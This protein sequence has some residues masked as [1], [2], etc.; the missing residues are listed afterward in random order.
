MPRLASS[1]ANACPVRRGNVSQQITSMPVPSCTSLLACVKKSAT[2][3]EREYVRIISPLLTKRW[4]SSQIFWLASSMSSMISSCITSLM[5]YGRGEGQ[6]PPPATPACPECGQI[7]CAREPTRR[8]WTARIPGSP[9]PRRSGSATSAPTSHHSPSSTSMY[10]S[11]VCCSIMWMRRGITDTMDSATET[12]TTVRTHRL[13]LQQ[14]IRQKTQIVLV[15]LVILDGEVFNLFGTGVHGHIQF[16][17]AF[18]MSSCQHR[19]QSTLH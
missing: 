12:N 8:R 15:L 9:P 18:R 3:R 6:L 13:F 2:A 11:K 16:Q 19:T 17:T 1:F 14:T 4:H 10:R 7:A 5:F